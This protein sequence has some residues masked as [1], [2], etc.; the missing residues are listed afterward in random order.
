MAITS[1]ANKKLVEYLEDGM[2]VLIL[3]GHGLGDT[4]MFM[5]VFEALRRAYPG[6]DF[7]L[8]VENGQERLFD[9]SPW[10]EADYDLT[11]VLHYP[12]AESTDM[13][14]SE[15]CCVQEIGIDPSL[16]AREFATLPRLESPLV[17]VHFNGTAL[18]DSVNCPESHA[19]R[20]WEDILDA[21]LVPF[22]VHYEHLFHNPVNKRF[23]FADRSVRGCSPTVPNLVGLIQSCRGFVGVASGPLTIAL[24]VFP[25]RV[26]YLQKLHR[27]KT[28]SRNSQVGIFDIT[29]EYDTAA[30]K[31]WLGKLKQE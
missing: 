11:F 31:N 8:Y 21:G 18:P 24:S 20:I 17:A 3:F 15:Y 6:V 16:I 27:L 10:N 12:M 2:K 13:T 5:P 14:K 22:E 23:P 30:V 28:Y 7:G 19:R 9:S 4:M 26:L 25:E 29:G 1:Y